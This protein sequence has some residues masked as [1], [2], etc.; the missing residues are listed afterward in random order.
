MARMRKHLQQTAPGRIL[1][2]FVYPEQTN[3]ATP[4]KEWSKRMGKQ[5]IDLCGDDALV[6]LLAVNNFH[7][8]GALVHESKVVTDDRATDSDRFLGPRTPSPNGQHSPRSPQ[9]LQ[10]LQHHGQ[11]G[12]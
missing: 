5:K 11:H 9:F 7:K 3:L 6:T 4:S 2:S 10:S 12:H 1:T 8:G